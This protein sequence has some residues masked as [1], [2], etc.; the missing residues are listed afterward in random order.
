M[1]PYDTLSEVGVSDEED[2]QSLLET[3]SVGSVPETEIDE[4]EAREAAHAV[5]LRSDAMCQ[6]LMCSKSGF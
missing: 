3:S 2:T 4:E 6:S 1:Q 5:C